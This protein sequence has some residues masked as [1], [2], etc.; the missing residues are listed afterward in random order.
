MLFPFSGSMR[1]LTLLE[2]TLDIES[3]ISVDKVFKGNVYGKILAIFYLASVLPFLSL[4]HLSRLNLILPELYR[5]RG[6]C[7]ENNNAL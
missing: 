3:Y 1:N 5:C 4:E 2:V 6:A 7:F